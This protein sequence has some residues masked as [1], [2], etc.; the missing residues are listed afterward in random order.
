VKKK[1]ETVVN[2][3]HNYSPVE[4]Y[5]L[6]SDPLVLK[7]IEWFRDQK[8]ALMIHWGPYSQL[9]IVESWA[10]S[11]E[12]AP[13]SRKCVDWNVTGDEF[14]RQYFALNR[15]FN[16]IRFEPDQW[17]DIAQKSGF[18]YLIF[19]TKHHDG[20]CMYD[21]H[22]SDYKVTAPDCPYHTSRYAD[23][24]GALFHAFRNRNIGIAC[25][26]SKA[27][28]HIGS[29][30]QDDETCRRFQNRGPSYDPLS[31]PQEWEK[32]VTY[33]RNQIL[34]LGTGYGP[35]DIMWFDAGW[36][37]AGNGQDIRLGSI[38]EEVRKSQPGMLSCDRTV[39]GAYENYITPE[40]CVPDQPIPVPWES[41]ITL[42]TSFSFR[43]EDHYK[44]PGEVI[45]LLIDVVC[46]GGNL[47]INVGPQPDGR[48]PEGAVNTL[49]EVGKWLSQYGEAIYGTRPVYPYKK[50]NLAFTRK[51]KRI[52]AIQ[53]PDGHSAET[54]LLLPITE[55]I[56]RIF[57]M[58]DQNDLEVQMLPF[59]KRPDGY[60]IRPGSFTADQ[61]QGRI[62]VLECT[63]T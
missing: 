23:I 34:E 18:R 54:A 11:D 13:W 60:L 57:C 51:G 38:V 42:G 12:D 59:E 25:Y 36:V 40:Q 39:G 46:K 48:L 43:Y 33:T 52:Y 22:F 32:F 24:A 63:Q 10:L 26:F 16:P 4:D 7:K 14:K 61:A 2:G 53:L 44:S 5:I 6:P 56:C 55:N 62:F 28:W 19:T 47:A 50:D 49:L 21:S 29:Y 41:C 35:I 20:F 58:H 45:S 27:D 8:F 3:T 30:W 9:G 17:A 1:K 37:N 15:T 31:N